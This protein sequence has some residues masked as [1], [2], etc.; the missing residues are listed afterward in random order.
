MKRFSEL[1]TFLFN[2]H[3][4]HPFYSMSTR[5]FV[6]GSGMSSQ[7]WKIG[8][9]P[10]ES[11]WSWSCAAEPPQQSIPSPIASIVRPDR[12]HTH[13]SQQDIWYTAP[14]LPKLW[15]QVPYQAGAG[16]DVWGPN[17][18]PVMITAACPR[19]HSPKAHVLGLCTFIRSAHFSERPF[20]AP[21]HQYFPSLLLPF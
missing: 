8:G 16:L 11:L 19:Q 21:K 20:F 15:Q 6:C 13:P 12:R 1:T 7:S 4:A 14:P 5:V 17:S 10:A 3:F 9:P 2:F 18:V